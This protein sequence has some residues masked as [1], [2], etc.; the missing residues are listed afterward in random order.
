MGQN[1]WRYRYLDSC[2]QAILTADGGYLLVGDTNSSLGGDITQSGQDLQA[3]NDCQ[4]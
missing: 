2:R 1:L 4:D 3:F